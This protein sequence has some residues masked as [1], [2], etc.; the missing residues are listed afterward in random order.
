MRVRGV[1]AVLVAVASAIALTGLT[2][3]GYVRAPAASAA[4]DVL[5]QPDGDVGGLAAFLEVRAWPPSTTDPPEDDDPERRAAFARSFPVQEAAIR[6]TGP[7]ED[8]WAVLIGINE[9]LGAVP[10][11]FVSREDA[12]RLRALLL[13][14]GWSDDR[15]VLLTDRDATGDMI[16]ESVAWLARKT[17]PESTVVFHYSG[18]SK[19]WYG[20][21]GRI[22]DQALWPTDDDFVRRG[23]LAEALGAVT[24]DALWGNVA[25]CEAA[26]FALPGLTAPGR[27]WTF[28]S[29]ADEKSYED[30]EAGHSVWGAFLLDQGLWQH[31]E[32]PPS[33]QAAF[34]DAAPLAR[35]YTS[36]QVPYGPQ[37]PVLVDELGTPFDLTAVPTRVTPRVGH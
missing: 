4:A 1:V 8:G 14:A 34:A 36:L 29:E 30:P 31:G 10:D 12:E 6:G 27:V 21:G 11:N 26:G 7:G 23:E 18:H 25:A 2:Y 24:H 19:K 3:V 15:I 17:G 9:H 35:H 28:S 13:R 5:V 22:D 37:T 20:P 32:D 16:R 33:V